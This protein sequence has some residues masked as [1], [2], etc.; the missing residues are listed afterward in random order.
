MSRKGAKSRTHGRTPRSTGTKAKRGVSR[1]DETQGSLIK[2]LKAHA[3]DLEKKLEQ[4][5]HDLAEAREQQAATADVL[6][7]ISRSTFDPQTVLDTLVQS[8]AR[9]CD[10]E[11]AFM[12]RSE[13]DDYWPSYQLVASHAFSQDY[14]QYMRGRPII[15]GRA[16]LVGRTA[17]EGRPV[18]IP[19]CLA[20]L[21]YDWPESQKRGNYRSMLGVPVLRGGAIGVLALMRSAVRP[22]SEKQIEL[23]TTLA[24]QAVI[25]IENMRLFDDVQARTRDLTESLQQ[26]I[27]TANVLK[28]ISRSAFDLQPVFQTVAESAARLCE[29]ERAFIFRF[30]GELLRSVV[31]YNA[32]P[33]LTEFIE[34][35]PTRPGRYSASGRAALELRTIHILD[36]RADPEY[37]Y[38][39]RDVEPIRTTLAVPILKRDELLG[40]MVIYRLEV[41]PF[42]DK[43]IA[44]V[45]TFADQAAIAIETVR[46]LDELKVRTSELARSVE[47]LRALGEVSQAVSSTLDLKTVFNTIVAKSV[48]LSRTEAGAIYVLDEV[49]REFQLRATYGMSEELIAAIRDMHDEISE[50]VG[51]ETETHQPRQVADLCDLP[52][53]SVND[54]ILRAG[55]R[56]RLLVPLMRSND[57]VGAL[58]VRRKEPGEFPQAVVSLMQTFAEQSAI[59]LENARLFNEIARKSRELEIASQHKSHFVANMSHELRTPLAAILG[60]AE[61][62]Q[63]G[64]YGPQSDK[65]S[66]ALKRIRSNGK[67]LL[68]LINTVL[69][70]AKVEFG[71]IQLEPCGIFT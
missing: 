56:A 71:A 55:Y 21:E 48:Q 13:G 65:S 51:L 9:L 39:S 34:K 47:E 11:G 26:Q 7:V 20:D 17:L 28:V 54:T 32:S 50:A 5:T 31:A 64:F 6:K 35:N 33:E 38:G 27:A 52:P 29:A 67:H 14:V 59:A 44:L 37:G 19:D 61:L 66:D 49:Q 8:A 15:P 70:I 43:Q 60:Y 1:S 30:D 3:R 68:G 69:D 24:D 41:E 62:M 10:A 18:H 53:T 42:T 4:R 25:A 36:V 63:E 23:L 40:V 16:T 58:V 57:V 46:L 45:E 12:F 22:F 2:T